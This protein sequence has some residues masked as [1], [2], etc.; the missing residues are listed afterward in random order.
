MDDGLL[1]NSCVVLS[2]FSGLTPGNDFTVTQV[3]E[4]NLIGYLY[5]NPD[6]RGRAG[7]SSSDGAQRPWFVV[8]TNR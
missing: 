1:P 3:A 5:A 2:G 6:E 7:R 8:F 4:G